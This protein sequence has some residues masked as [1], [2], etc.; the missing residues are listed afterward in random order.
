MRARRYPAR[1]Y[2][3][4]L[5]I[6]VGPGYLHVERMGRGGPAVVLLHGFGSSAF[7]WRAVAP[8]LAARGLVVVSVDLLGY[9]ES[10]RPLSAPTGPAAQ[11]EYLELALTALRLGSASVLGQGLGALVGLLLAADDPKRVTRIGCLD[12]LDPDDLPGPAIRSMQ[13]HSALAALSAKSLFGA[14]PL[15]EPLVSEALAPEVPHAERLIARYLAPFAGDTGMADLL[16]LAGAVTLT[17]D[18]RARLRGVGGP[19]HFWLGY[20]EGERHAETVAAWEARLPAA[21]I[22]AS[23]TREPSGRLLSETAPAE[24]LTALGAWLT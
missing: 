10:D 16:Q 12:P 21:S 4:H 9:G 19:V 24:L 13:R 7:Q 17:D 20:R 1:V 5:R 2:T 15:L 18:E 3:E 22:S 8:T 23:E 11:A 14:R 6:P